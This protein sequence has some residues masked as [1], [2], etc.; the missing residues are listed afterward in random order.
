MAS[1]LADL[2]IRQTFFRQTLE[3]SKFAKLCRYT[4]FNLAIKWIN[5]CMVMQS[6]MPTVPGPACSHRGSHAY[7]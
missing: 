4:V 5:P 2:F 3:S 1:P 7:S 6:D